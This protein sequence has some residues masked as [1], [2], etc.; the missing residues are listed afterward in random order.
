MQ[1][2]NRTSARQYALLKKQS[3]D[4]YIQKLRFACEWLGI[5]QGRAAEYI[6]LLEEF[7]RLKPLSSENILAYYE[8]FDIVELFELWEK[9]V[10]E[11]PGLKDKIKAACKKG[12]IL[13]DDENVSKSKNRP[14]NDAF[15]FILSGKFLAAGIHITSVDGIFPQGAGGK[16]KADISFEWKG[17]KL[18]VECKRVKSDKLLR[19]RAR[20]ARKQISRRQRRGIIAIDCSAL[21]RPA[22]TVLE[23]S[24]PSH[25]MARVSKWMQTNIEPKI[26]ESLSPRILGFILFSR[27]PAM[28][29]TEIV[30]SNDNFYRRCDCFSS[31]LAV[32]NSNCSDTNVLQSIAQKLR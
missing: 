12:P 11:F 7:A 9:R 4:A 1:A 8:S 25:A 16:S 26:Q 22:G 3:T 17:R 13:S 18:V 23:T 24:L 20:E 15:G 10:D 21:Y 2:S 6:R 5:E 29:A 31:I 27:L 19:R 32:G 14:R 28:T 30:D